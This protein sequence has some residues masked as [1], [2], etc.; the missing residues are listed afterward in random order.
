MRRHSPTDLA[1]LFG[2]VD[3]LEHRRDV[4]HTPGD[5]DQPFNWIA[6]RLRTEPEENP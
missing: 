3:I 6:G 5:T 4:H 2:D 1:E